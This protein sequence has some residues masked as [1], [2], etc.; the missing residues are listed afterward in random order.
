MPSRSARRSGLSAIL[1]LA[2]LVTA[3]AEDQAPG[4]HGHRADN[5]KNIFHLSVPDHPFDLIL[6]RPEANSVTLSVLTYQDAEG[7]LS[8][9]VEGATLTVRTPLR[10]FKKGETA[11][12]VLAG[13]QADTRYHYQINLRP[14]G[15]AP[16][17]RSEDYSFPT[18]RP[19]GRNFSF[20]L[21]AD[22]HLDERTT[23]AL[24]ERTLD[25]I[26]ADQPDF[27]LDLGNLFM[28]DKPSSRSEAAD[29]FLAQRYYLGRIGCSVPIF[30]ALGTHDGE[31]GKYDD[32]SADSLAVWSTQIRQRLFP[33]PRADPFY[34]GN[35]VPHPRSGLLQNYYA[36][37]WGVVLFVVL[38]PSGFPAVNMAA[39][40]AG[41]GRW[42][43]LSTTGWSRRWSIAG[44]RLNSSSSTT[45]SAATRRRAEGSRS[46]ASMNG[47]AKTSTAARASSHTAPTGRS[48]CI[49]CCCVTTSPRSLRPTIIF[50]PSKNSTGS[51]T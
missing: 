3:R 45:C 22:V 2:V 4:T 10:S 14:V 39:A 50:T 8:Y 46:P 7:F 42:A 40:M 9:S 20:T 21:T 34:T 44:P 6:A 36:W 35:R 30:L 15:T 5:A 41:A 24:Y 19:P 16:F 47:A 27:H 29:Q 37:E 17:T 51:F 23:G 13:L 33:N 48:R 12:L 11:E 18:A 31:A 38:V 32:G 43:P 28:T 26:R 25:N 49:P 1:L